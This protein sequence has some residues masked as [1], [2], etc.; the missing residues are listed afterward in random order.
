MIL[1]PCNNN[2]AQRITF[3]QIQGANNLMLVF[4]H[5]IEAANGE[6]GNNL[7]VWINYCNRAAPGQNW[8]KRT[9]GSIFNPNSGRC[10]APFNGSTADGTQMVITDCNGSAH[11]RWNTP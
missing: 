3:H 7:V 11:Q 1:W 6:T 4:G 10:L 9:D 2:L 5:C 8:V